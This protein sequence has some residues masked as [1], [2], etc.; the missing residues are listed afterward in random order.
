MATFGT[1]EPIAVTVELGV[2]EVRLRASE[3]AD[4]VVVVRP[5]DP[6]KRGDVA[7][8]EQTSV[9]YANGR[10]LVRGPRGWRQ[11]AP[12]RGGESI[13]VQIDLPAGSSLRGRAGVSAL[14]CSG[15]LGDCRFHLG[16]G[17]VRL[18]DAG[19]VEVET[20]AGDVTIGSVGGAAEVTTSSGAVAIDRVE[21]TA[22]IRDRNGDTW[23]GEV[24][25]DARV[26]AANGSISIDVARSGVVAKTANGRIRLGQVERGAVVAQSAFGAVEVGVREGVAVWLD[27][28]T[29]FGSVQNDL[30]ETERPGPGEDAVEVHART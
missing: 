16:V 9:E 20:G 12:W 3:R 14:R 19:R 18:D 11:W 30:H 21:G 7:A 8:V 27:L 5:G 2:G 13:D 10:L 25:G 28:E 1:P 17:D 24:I 4:T 22:V 15:R 23:I 26:S 6:A 29:R